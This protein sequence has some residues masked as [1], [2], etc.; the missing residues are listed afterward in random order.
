MIDNKKTGGEMVLSGVAVVFKAVIKH[1]HGIVMVESKQEKDFF[2]MTP[3]SYTQL[4]PGIMPSEAWGTV[5]CW[6]IT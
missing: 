1:S 5:S 3:N 6:D 4:C 2:L